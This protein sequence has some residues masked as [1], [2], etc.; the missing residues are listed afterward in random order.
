MIH[1][2]LIKYFYFCLT[3]LVFICPV[4]LTFLDFLPG[5]ILMWFIFLMFYLGVKSNL[6]KLTPRF[7]EYHI[8]NDNKFLFFVCISYL[9]FYPIYIKFYTGSNVVSALRGL[10]NGVS[11]YASYQENFADSNL[12]VFSINKIP[13]II[14]HGFLRFL[15]IITVFRA[16]VYKPKVFLTEK[17]SITLMT[18]VIIIVGLSRGTSF[19]L[20]ELFVIF[21]F[22]YATK[23]M[24]SN[25]T[26]IFPVKT[27]AKLMLVVILLS[28]YFVYN[29]N[30]RMGD[31]FDHVE[32]NNFDKESIV[33]YISK[34]LAIILFSLYGYFLFGLYYNSVVITKIW[35]S[36]IPGFFSIFIPSGINWF[37]IDTDYR[38]YLG[39]YVELGAMWNP[40]SSIFIDN[41][42]II[43]TFIFIF[44]ISRF[45]SKIYKLI[46]NDLSA[47]ILLFYIF[48]IFISMPIGN[49]ISSSSANQIVILISLISY[50][51]KWMKFKS[52]FSNE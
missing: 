9:I 24:L 17:L 51:M 2:K 8:K 10:L 23:R 39:K 13:F 11:N 18:F 30:I 5:L 40:D 25:K 50:K 27:L 35:F 33:Y 4:K 29:I 48:Y 36:S 20:F 16:I 49:F 3:I 42:G 15:F 22:A 34:P 19:E 37:S 14:G 26:T 7:E 28:S 45:S 1:V 46:V 6:T 31:A 52:K 43:F 32:L 44:F 38:E 12:S 21:I 41:Y 47:L